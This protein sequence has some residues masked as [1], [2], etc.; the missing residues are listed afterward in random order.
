MDVF[1]NSLN[2]AHSKRKITKIFRFFFNFFL[3]IMRCGRKFEKHMINP[4][5]NEASTSKEHIMKRK[6][7]SIL[8]YLDSFKQR[9]THFSNNF[10]TDM[11]KL[12]NAKKISVDQNQ[13]I[14]G[15]LKV[16]NKQ[17]PD[18]DK[19]IENK[20]KSLPWRSNSYK[21]SKSLLFEK[22]KGK[23][24]NMSK[25]ISLGNIRESAA[26]Y[27]YSLKSSHPQTKELKKKKNFLLIE[28]KPQNYSN[29]NIME[30]IKKN[31]AHWQILE[32]ESQNILNKLQETNKKLEKLKLKRLEKKENS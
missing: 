14:K 3:R 24:E 30:K 29:E 12:A 16:Q 11:E 25:S 1:K 22:N 10:P 8:D 2:E 17:I 23:R 19:K 27:R 21:K 7:R 5:L 13:I 4:S 20:K 31:S 32:E 9:K 15:I 18:N 26:N 6:N 28:K